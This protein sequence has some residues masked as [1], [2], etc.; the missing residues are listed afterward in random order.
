MSVAAAQADAF[1]KEALDGEFVFT[2]RD[3]GGSPAPT[4]SSGQRAMPFWSKRSR[5][6]KIIDNVEAYGG[7]RVIEVALDDWLKKWLP[8]LE[9][10]GL[11]V[12]LNWS[13]KSAVG[14]DVSPADAVRNLAARKGL[15]DASRSV[16]EA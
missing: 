6:Q 9:E 13:G 5:A 8:G 11:F 3:D 16:D 12:G 14:Y 2:V 10:D 15:R 7:M 1:Y 4:N